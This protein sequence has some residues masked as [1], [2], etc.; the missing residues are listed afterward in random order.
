MNRRS[1]VVILCLLV[2]SAALGC[3]PLGMF[4]PTATPTLTPTPIPTATK[5]PTLT[6]IPT[7]TQ[8]PTDT[9]TPIP[10]A[11]TVPTDTPTPIP[12]AT[13]VPPATPTV[14]PA[15]APGPDW[16]KFEMRGAE[17][18]LPD[19]FE[20]GDPSEDLDLIIELIEAVGP[21]FEQAAA[22]LRQNPEAFVFWAFDSDISDLKFLTNVTI[23]SQRVPSVITVETFVDLMV[24]QL[25]S[26]FN[27]IEQEV[28]PVG[29]YEAGRLVIDF[30]LP[31]VEGTQLIYVFLE[32]GSVWAVNFTTSE[33]EFNER[34]PVFDE[35]VR[36]FRIR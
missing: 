1:L 3:S 15:V 28:V 2:L 35:S 4:Q 32:E 8:V 5:T 27:V 24:G 29:P 7:A 19:S 31:G 22:A 30:A 17:L 20:G 11:T 14:Q 26:Q 36:T 33:G 13:T 21:D 18:W 25:T 6:P 34:L 23:A 10:T 9:P 12:T 16:K